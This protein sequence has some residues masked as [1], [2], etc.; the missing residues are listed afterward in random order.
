MGPVLGGFLT[1]YLGWRSIFYL[2]VPLCLLV[3]VLMLLKMKG[4]NGW[5]AKVKSW[6]DGEH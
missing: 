2:I 4:T 6:T 3:M 5:N 1:Q